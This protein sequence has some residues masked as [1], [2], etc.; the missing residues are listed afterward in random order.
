MQAGSEH[1]Q[2]P[3][4][5]EKADRTE[6]GTTTKEGRQQRKQQGPH[7]HSEERKKTRKT[8]RRNSRS[9]KTAQSHEPHRAAVNRR[10]LLQRPLG[11]RALE[12]P[13]DY[14]PPARMAALVAQL[15]PDASQ[16]LESDLFKLLRLANKP[17]SGPWTSTPQDYELPV[18]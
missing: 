17:H 12:K 15:W 9:T 18:A 5:G 3:R 13:G 7:K 16:D 11:L 14:L 2:D 8:T 10:K 1:K 4:G 6:T